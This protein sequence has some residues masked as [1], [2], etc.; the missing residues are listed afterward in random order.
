MFEQYDL[1]KQVSD[2]DYKAIFPDLAAHLSRLQREA[3]DLD[4]PVIITAD[5][6]N[7]SGI[8]T[9][10]HQ[11]VL[12]LDPR[13]YSYHAASTPT[14][15][16]ADRPFLWRFWLRTPTTGRMA[17]FDR[18]WYSRLTAE[19][20]HPGDG[21]AP[22][23]SLRE[24]TR[25]ER[26]LTDA[27]AVIIKLFL[28]ISRDEQAERIERI[29]QEPAAAVLIDGHETVRL[30]HYELYLPVFEGMIAATDTPNAPWTV[31]EAHDRNFTVIKGMSTVVH[32]L[33]R[34]IE[35]RRSTVVPRY[36]APLQPPS[37]KLLDLPDPS[38]HALSK[39]EY[40][41]AINQYGEQITALQYSLYRERLP[42]I[43]VY[44]GW[45]AAGKGGAIMRLTR[46]LNP[47]ICQVEPIGPPNEAESRHH[48]LWR[49]WRDLP[50]KGHIAV[51]DRSWYGRVLVERVEGLSSPSEVERAYNEI[52]EFEEALTDWGALLVKFWLHI[53]RNE[54]LHRFIDREEDP[55]K[56]WKITPDDW[57][58]RSRWDIYAA[59]VAEMLERTDTKTA[60][61]TVI[62]TNDKRYARVKCLRTVAETVEQALK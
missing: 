53:D 56:Q 37:N 2:E 44:E 36:P 6:W 27:G 25:F 41:E 29:K 60:P 58:N 26:H 33:E 17:I 47:R 30:E 55:E 48:Y 15:E 8:S 54:Q 5:G 42:L 52:N 39:K 14:R 32:A 9:M 12:A 3:R 24:I 10:L 21:G 45:D 28:H 31:V 40:H 62:S 46:R 38:K 11:F 19:R 43:V 59:S 50:K 20:I 22:E 13:L 49:F 18:S 61:W 23:R 4:L 51:F 34:A 35:E 1:T 7:L 16:E 57:R